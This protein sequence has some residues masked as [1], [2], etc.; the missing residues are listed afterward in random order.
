METKNIK[1]SYNELKSERRFLRVMT[2]VYGTV[3]ASAVFGAFE[4]SKIHEIT[5]PSGHVFAVLG[6]SAF[7]LLPTLTYK[8]ASNITKLLRKEE[9]NL[10]LRNK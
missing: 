10:Q 8:K 5:K 2:S 3:F 1:K 6:V 4:L 7:A 9:K